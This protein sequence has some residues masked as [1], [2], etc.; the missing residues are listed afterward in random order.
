MMKF[1]MLLKGIIEEQN[2]EDLTKLKKVVLKLENHLK[3]TNEGLVSLR[4]QLRKVTNAKLRQKY[5]M[6]THTMVWEQ[7]TI[8]KILEDYKAKAA[9][10]NNEKNS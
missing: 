5:L 2:G 3:H 8:R 10:V 1:I 6:Q 7:Q 4:H 9:K